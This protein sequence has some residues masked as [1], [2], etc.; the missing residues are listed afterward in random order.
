MSQASKAEWTVSSQACY[1]ARRSHC[2]LQIDHQAETIDSL[3]RES[4]LWKDQF[5]RVEDERCKLAA[6]IDEM[7]TEQLLV[8]MAIVFVARRLISFF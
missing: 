6:R 1:Y 4:Q 3:R 8:R 7:V 2:M 5:M